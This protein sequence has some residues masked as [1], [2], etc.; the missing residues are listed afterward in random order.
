MCFQTF[1]QQ[2]AE[3][4]LPKGE[5]KTNEKI[6]FGI[7]LPEVLQEKIS[8][9]LMNKRGNCDAINPYLE[10]ELRVYAEFTNESNPHEKIVIDA[11]YH[12]L[13]DVWINEELPTP[14]N[15]DNYSASEYKDLGKYTLKE[16]KYPFLLRFAAPQAGK[17]KAQIFIAEKDKEIVS[18][19]PI[20]FN[21]LPGENDF[22]KIGAQQRFFSVNGKGFIPVGFNNSWTE[23]NPKYDSLLYENLC[24]F[25]H[26]RNQK[27][28]VTEG[29]LDDVVSPRVY[30]KYKESMHELVEN[31]GNLMRTI[32][33][34]SATE[35][36]W[37]ALGDYTK[38]L[39]M[40]QELDSIL[41]LAEDLNLFLLWNL[42]IHYS[43]QLSDR[44]YYRK[45]AWD[46][47][48]N[49]KSFAYKSLIPSNNPLD[50]FVNE[51]AKK[52][53]QQRL[54][55]ILSRWGY[56]TKILAWELFSEISN[57]GSPKADNND[58]Y[59]TGEN[60]KL[61]RD[62][63]VEMAKYIKSQ[64]YGKIHLLTA[65][66]GG[67]KH[68]EDDTF[69]DP[70]FDFM[71]SNIYDFKQPD[72]GAFW[73]E[74]VNKR[75]LNDQKEKGLSFSSYSLNQLHQDKADYQIKKPMIYSEFDPDDIKCD[76]LYIENK[77]HIWQSAF[78]G[79]STALTWHYRYKSNLD[80]IFKQIDSFISPIDWDKNGWHPGA[81][82][83]DQGN[84]I[85]QEKYAKMM[86]SNNQLTSPVDVTFLRS[87][88]KNFAIGVITN[89]T[90]NLKNQ[91]NCPSLTGEN[92]PESYQSLE[93]PQHINLKQ[94]NIKIPGMNRGKYI[95]EYYYVR[96]ANNIIST[97]MTKGKNLSL[98]FTI[99]ANYLNYIVVFKV[100]K[101]ELSWNQLK[102]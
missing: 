26:A 5:I 99:P 91:G 19:E 100:K 40:A 9:F 34:P 39:H 25:D 16:T 27:F 88:D 44:A 36:E 81:M 76:D 83:N 33:Y 49:G 18:Y 10:W 23:T 78:S 55:Y 74:S 41:E 45:W 48:Q 95:I 57:V 85:Y 31:G 35:I 67:E 24:Y 102:K 28:Y 22:V 77:R 101:Q 92:W 80:D 6:E 20:Y 93:T 66:Y 1:A 21:V 14:Q 54:R 68:P 2:N 8:C 13:F 56:S 42:Q 79:L 90:F 51:E 87:E 69:H 3:I 94:T 70:N 75:Y 46:T 97:S 15:G 63:Q 38:R 47:K 52:F 32:M 73:I 62:W 71:S 61:Y 58:F 98:D 30:E 29:Y 53:Y 17:W 65:S 12:Q 11:F 72:F 64:Y 50:F 59:R 7:S 96:S 37:E 4:L 60:Y 84:W 82:S 86:N 89:K 43:F